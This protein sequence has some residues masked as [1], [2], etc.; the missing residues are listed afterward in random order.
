VEAHVQ[1]PESVLRAL[2]RPL[3]PLPDPLSLEAAEFTALFN[4]LLRCFR[5]GE[6]LLDDLGLGMP[7][8]RKRLIAFLARAQHRMTGMA[9]SGLLEWGT[10][11]FLLQH[12]ELFDTPHLTWLLERN[13]ELCAG[14]PLVAMEAREFMRRAVRSVMVCLHVIDDYR[15]ILDGA[16]SARFAS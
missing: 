8:S 15:E 1:Y 14:Y 9:G 5:T 13:D 2:R 10:R 16:L 3:D 12:S 7:E 6:H 4:M 11:Q